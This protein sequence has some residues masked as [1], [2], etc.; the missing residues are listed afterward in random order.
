MRNLLNDPESFRTRFCSATT[1]RNLAGIDPDHLREVLLKIHQFVEFG[2]VNTLDKWTPEGSPQT[3]VSIGCMKGGGRGQVKM[4]DPRFGICTDARAEATS[5]A[6]RLYLWV[7]HRALDRLPDNVRPFP[8]EGSPF[9]WRSGKN[10]KADPEQK[11]YQ[12]SDPLYSTAGGHRDLAKILIEGQPRVVSLPDLLKGLGKL[13]KRPTERAVQAVAPHAQRLGL[14]Q[15]CYTP[16]AIG[17][18]N[19]TI[20]EARAT[21]GKG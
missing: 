1:I 19:K 18:F 13:L 4:E 2:A 17:E 6:T 11:F 8:R 3:V 10:G 16:A 21:V 20:R 12:I 14:E 15:G 9:N 7:D 5:G